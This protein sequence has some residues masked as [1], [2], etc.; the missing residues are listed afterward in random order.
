MPVNLGLLYGSHVNQVMEVLVHHPRLRVVWLADGPEH[1]G[2]WCHVLLW[3]KAVLG[4]I[5]LLGELVVDLSCQRPRGAL[6]LCCCRFCRLYVRRH[7]AP[8]V[9][10]GGLPRGQGFVHGDGASTPLSWRHLR[11]PHHPHPAAM[12]PR[13]KFSQLPQ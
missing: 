2:C 3:V 5:A 11:F 9:A 12:L 7:R 13:S 8:L 10:T 6:V 1:H 4:T